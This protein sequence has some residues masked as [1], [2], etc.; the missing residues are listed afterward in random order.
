MLATV[1]Q[2][3]DRP[4]REFARN[5]TATS[6]PRT[7]IQDRLFDDATRGDAVFRRYSG[8][9]GRGPNAPAKK[10]RVMGQ[11]CPWIWIDAGNAPPP[12]AE[13]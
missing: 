10:K 1:Q 9:T 2:R 11:T 13:G 3:E 6:E 8:V 4:Q 5:K 12:P 7:L